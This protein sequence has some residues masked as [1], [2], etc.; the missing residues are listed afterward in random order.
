MRRFRQWLLA[1]TVAALLMLPLAQVASADP[2]D[3][4]IGGYAITTSGPST[5]GGA[6]P[7]SVSSTTAGDPGDGGIG[8]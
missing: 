2:G 8:N 1:A 5:S 3:G 4:G 6:P 7:I